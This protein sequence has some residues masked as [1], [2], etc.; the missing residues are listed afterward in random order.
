[1]SIVATMMKFFIVINSYSLFLFVVGRAAGF[2]C[3]DN[4]LYVVYYRRHTISV[5]T[6]DTF[7]EVSVITVDGLIDPADIIACHVDHQLY[8]CDRLGSMWRVSAV[9]PSDYEK[10]LPV[11]ESRHDF[12]TL[13]LTSGRLVVTSWRSQSLR[14]YSTVNKQLLRV[15]QL[16]DSV[17]LP[18]HAVEMSRDTFVVSHSQPHTA[19]SELFSFILC[20]LVLHHSTVHCCCLTCQLK[21]IFVF[22]N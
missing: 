11:D 14:Q 7:S 6:A 16:P 4:R 1:M 18:T 22:V 19:V 21:T 5:Y 15:I 9:N 2:T 17:R 20:L 8:V 10:W 12:Y 3:L 13:S